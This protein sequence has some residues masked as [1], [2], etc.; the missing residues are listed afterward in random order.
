LQHTY[1]L[2]EGPHDWIVWRKY[3]AEFLPLLFR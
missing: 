3:L 1:R 2:T